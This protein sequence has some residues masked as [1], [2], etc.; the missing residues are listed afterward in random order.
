MHPCLTALYI[1][2]HSISP[3]WFLKFFLKYFIY[4]FLDRREGREKERERNV[5]VWLPL[6][7]P[8]PGHLVCNLGMCPNWELNP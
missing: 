1:G 4:L 3:Y 2:N 5:N 8:T 6:A 7:C